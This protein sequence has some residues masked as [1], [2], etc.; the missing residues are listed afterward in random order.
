MA[1]ITNSELLKRIEVLEKDLSEN[2]RINETLMTLLTENTKQNRE[3]LE[4]LRQNN[5][6]TSDIH[7]YITVQLSPEQQVKN[8]LLNVGANLAG[9]TITVPNIVN[10]NR[11]K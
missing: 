6:H 5:K 1:D 10:L 3:L 4:L 8:F 9:N 11:L 7:D 2:T